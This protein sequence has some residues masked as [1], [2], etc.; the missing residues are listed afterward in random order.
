MAAVARRLSEG[1][2]AVRDGSWGT[3]RPDWLCGFELRGA[4]VGVVGAGR[5]GAA[6]CVSDVCRCRVRKVEVSFTLCL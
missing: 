5:I 4:T 3:W 6:V 1:I 2:D